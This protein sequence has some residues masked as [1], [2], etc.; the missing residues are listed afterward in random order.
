MWGFLLFLG[1]VWITDAE[2]GK[3]WSII[4]KQWERVVNYMSIAASEERSESEAF[5]LSE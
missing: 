5:I 3:V 4:H 1:A 2:S